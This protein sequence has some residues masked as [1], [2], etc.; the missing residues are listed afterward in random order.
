MFKGTHKRTP[1]K[2]AQSLESLGGTLNAF[3]GKEVTCYFANAQDIHLN[4][5]ILVY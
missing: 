4:H 5:S 3:T 2:I 1:F